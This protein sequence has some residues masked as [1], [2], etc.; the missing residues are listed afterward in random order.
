MQSHTW[1]HCLDLSPAAEMV[2]LMPMLQS[3]NDHHFEDIDPADA[4]YQ[5]F[6][7]VFK[8]FMTILNTPATVKKLT[9]H[10]CN[11]LYQMLRMVFGAQMHLLFGN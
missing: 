2:E 8:A 5:S 10:G 7:D 1:H 9:F 3:G 11:G 4:R 6:L